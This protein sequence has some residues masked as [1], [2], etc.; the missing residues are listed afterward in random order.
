MAERA[1]SLTAPL[2]RAYLDGLKDVTRRPLKALGP[3]TVYTRVPD[4]MRLPESARD[5]HGWLVPDL[6]E[7]F[8][9]PLGVPGDS[10]WIREPARVIDTARRLARRIIRGSPKGE[11]VVRLVYL[12]DMKTSGWVP[13]PDRLAEPVVGNG[14]PNGV[15]REGARLFAELAGL[16]AEPVKSITEEEAKREGM[17]TFFHGSYDF[18]WRAVPAA[19][20]NFRRVWT[21]IYGG[22]SWTE[23]W[24]WRLELRRLERTR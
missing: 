5:A 17:E 7:Q 16:G 19:V 15:H 11:R 23:G 10:V 14:V 6:G 20:A 9:C 13:Y 4:Y 18:D 3:P 24:C 2:V 1:L 8:T 22:A 12:A 21:G